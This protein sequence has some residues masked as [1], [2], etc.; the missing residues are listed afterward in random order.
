MDV[1][2]D[3]APGKGISNQAQVARPLAGGQVGDITDPKLVRS[4]WFRGV[5]H[6][7]GVALEAVMRVGGFSVAALGRHEQ[8]PLAQEREQGVAPTAQVLNPQLGSDFMQQLARTQPRQLAA[9]RLHLVEHG[10]VA[11]GLPG[12]ALAPLVVALPA[13]AV[14]LAAALAA[15]GFFRGQ[16]ANGRWKDFFGKA[17]PWSSSTTCNMV[18]NNRFRSVLSLSCFSYCFFCARNSVSS[19]L[20]RC[21]GLWAMAAGAVG[22]VSLPV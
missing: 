3:D 7:V 15:Q 13:H 5:F 8:A 18:R 6:P 17:M 11:L 19:C 21:S 22:D 1:V 4:R 14:E 10:L 2:A 12:L 16:L 9:H 20:M